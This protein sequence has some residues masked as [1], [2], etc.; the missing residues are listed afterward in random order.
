VAAASRC[1]SRSL[2]RHDT[3]I[4]RCSGENWSQRKREAIPCWRELLYSRNERVYGDQSERF[5]DGYEWDAIVEG[6]SVRIG[7]RSI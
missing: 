1:A 5:L 4:A 6:F 7:R 3:S 2:I